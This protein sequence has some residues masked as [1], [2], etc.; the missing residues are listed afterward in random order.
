M[1]WR[2][3][4]SVPKPSPKHALHYQVQVAGCSGEDTVDILLPTNFN[5]VAP[6]ST[7]GYILLLCR[8]TIDLFMFYTVKFDIS[9]TKHESMT[10]QQAK[11]LQTGMTVLK[12][13]QY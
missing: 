5:P 1:G 10:E 12:F 13:S 8:V 7:F 4:L 2:G 3:K 9:E 6:A 11:E